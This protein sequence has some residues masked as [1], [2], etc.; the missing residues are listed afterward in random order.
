MTTTVTDDLLQNTLIS[1][2]F[3]PEN[4]A[5]ALVETALHEL[6]HR[7]IV[8]D[9]LQ[10]P[11]HT[12][13]MLSTTEEDAPLIINKINSLENIGC[14]ALDPTFGYHWG[15]K[16]ATQSKI[17]VTNREELSLA[18]TPEVAKI[19]MAIHHSPEQA[20][21]FTIRHNTVAVITDGTAVLGL[22]DIGPKAALP[23]MEGKALLFKAFANVDA[24]P[25]CL[26]TTDVD[27]FIRTV[28]YL[29]PN[30]G[31]INLEDI[32][33]PRCFEIERRLKANLDIPVFHDDQHGTAAVVAAAFINALK[34]TG[35]KAPDLKIV[36]SG[37]GAAGTACK[38][39]LLQLGA[40]NIIGCDRKGAL[41]ASRTDLDACKRAFAEST[42]PDHLRGSLA[43]VIKG[44]DVFIGLSGPDTLT[45]PDL[46]NMNKDPIVFA[47]ANPIPE[48]M[49]EI[50]APHV[51][52]IATGRSDYPNQINNLLAFPGIF[53]GALDCRARDITP[54]MQLA[55]AHA[56]ANV[57]DETALSPTYII[58]SVFD[59]AVVP[60]V[61]NAVMRTALQAGVSRRHS[62]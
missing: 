56:I 17:N 47:M 25:L 51:A 30:F 26:A 49:P 9:R 35:K 46:K 15:G 39:M 57:V 55:A 44:A 33:A 4:N 42:N 36:F 41:A 8:L 5:A 37:V 7:A 59:K 62:G 52:I 54:E 2:H 14:C 12:T 23:V 43:D 20:D 27:E 6:G 21:I 48:I 19:C 31:G 24:F 53:R 13:L 11:D 22:G 38:N 16:I 50:A 29:A 3:S 60:A 1:I 28:T 18:Y 40:V 61:A 58:P 32:A 45:V 34:V 10:T